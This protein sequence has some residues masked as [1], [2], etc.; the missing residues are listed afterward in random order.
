[1]LRQVSRALGSRG[2]GGGVLCEE[3]ETVLWTLLVVRF[4]PCA[5]LARFLAVPGV[6]ACRYPAR[7][8]IAVGRGRCS[9]TSE[10][11]CRDQRQCS[12][13]SAAYLRSPV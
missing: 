8:K 2:G 10:R 12:L 1:M 5:S 11:P 9:P 6:V 4:W 3:S 7:L 13:L